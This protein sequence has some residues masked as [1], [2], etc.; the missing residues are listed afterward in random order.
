M[1]SSNSFV[2][3]RPIPVKPSACKSKSKS[4]ENS[5]LIHKSKN[6][7]CYTSKIFSD[8]GVFLSSL[9]EPLTKAHSTGIGCR[10]LPDLVLIEAEL[11]RNHTKP[12]LAI[13]KHSSRSSL[14][15]DI[16][17]EEATTEIKKE[18]EVVPLRPSNP[19]CCDQ[20]FSEACSQF[21]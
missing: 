15:S 20:L 5:P 14:A 17:A 8:S 9:Q 19:M 3:H 2:L 13:E 6:S 1:K 16:T 7:E 10:Y 11:L 21:S 18:G 4:C 12:F